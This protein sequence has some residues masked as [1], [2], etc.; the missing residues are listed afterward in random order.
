VHRLN[1]ATSAALDAAPVR[2]R[3]E[4]AGINMVPAEQRAPDYSPAC[5][6]PRSRNGLCRSGGAGAKPAY[7]CK[8]AV[9]WL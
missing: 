5:C 8:K 3:I 4:T 2:G 1:S 9:E 7:T 6:G